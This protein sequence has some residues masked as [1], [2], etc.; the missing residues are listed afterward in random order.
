[1]LLSSALFYFEI[2]DSKSDL[3]AFS[4]DDLPNMLSKLSHV[5]ISDKVIYTNGKCENVERSVHTV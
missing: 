4:N 2:C 5:L 1:M 3:E